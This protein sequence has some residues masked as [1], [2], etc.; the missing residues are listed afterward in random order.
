MRRI[1]Q[2]GDR[3]VRFG[4]IS[5]SRPDTGVAVEQ[6]DAKAAKEQD[7]QPADVPVKDKESDPAA[8]VEIEK[9]AKVDA[10]DGFGLPIRPSTS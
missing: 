8:A 6:T 7:Q 4:S 1:S 10:P 2:S 9:E 3:K 5:T